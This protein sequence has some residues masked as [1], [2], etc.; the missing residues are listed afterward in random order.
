VVSDRGLRPNRVRAKAAAVADPG[1]WDGAGAAA[2][3][4]RG[5]WWWSRT[6]WEG[7]PER[8]RAP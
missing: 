5:S 7:R 3:A 4:R 8:V 1:L 6:V 2:V